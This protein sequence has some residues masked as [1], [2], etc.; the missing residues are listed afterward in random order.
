MKRLGQVF[1]IILIIGQPWQSRADPFQDATWAYEAGD[2][3]AAMALWLPLAEGG[4]AQAQMI[5]GIMHEDG[6]GVPFDP[7][8]AHMWQNVA[9]ANGNEK[10]RQLRDTVAR[11][12][13]LAQ[14]TEAQKRAAGWVIEHPRGIT[15]APVSAL[16]ELRE[17]GNGGD[18]EAQFKHAEIYD[19]GKGT[20]QDF[21]KALL[22]YDKAA[23][24]GNAGA[25]RNL[26]IMYYG[27][28]GVVQNHPEAAKWL[29]LAADQGDGQ[30]QVIL[31][32]MHERGEGMARDAVRAHMWL[33]L[34]GAHGIKCGRGTRDELAKKMT[35]V[36]IAKAQDLARLWMAAHDP[37]GPPVDV[38]GIMWRLERAR[39]GDVAQMFLVGMMYDIGHDVRQDYGEAVSWYL[40][41]AAKGHVGAQYNLGAAYY[42]GNGV[43]QDFVEAHKWFSIANLT[44][45][46]RA[47]VNRDIISKLMTPAQLAAAGQRKRDWLAGNAGAADPN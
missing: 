38:D 28:R 31:G 35:P 47:I 46:K 17:R 34:A 8:L 41:A 42:L 16:S 4:N 33:N 29:R 15:L 7:I 12:M 25:Q 39:R 27:A 23:R 3:A 2:F 14:V 32:G 30:A 21:G 11:Y 6:R 22:W 40:K 37:S 1:A 18:A 43:A 36:E 19:I 13:T 45:L 24:K 9:A 26:G 20:P 10:A 5:L 44:G